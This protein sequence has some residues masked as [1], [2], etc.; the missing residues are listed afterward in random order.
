MFGNRLW[1]MGTT[2]VSDAAERIE[3]AAGSVAGSL[4]G[5]LPGPQWFLYGGFLLLS[6]VLG[7]FLFRILAS[8]EG[9][10]APVR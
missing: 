1:G 7:W 3:G 5:P 9:L 2:F 8:E 10:R 4:P 6:V